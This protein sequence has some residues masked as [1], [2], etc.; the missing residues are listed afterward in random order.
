MDD[1]ELDKELGQNSK[2]KVV[3]PPAD[4]AQSKG[5]GKGWKDEL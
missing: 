1:S 2:I 4:H 5:N 3:L